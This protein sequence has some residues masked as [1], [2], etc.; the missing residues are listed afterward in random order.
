MWTFST[1]ALQILSHGCCSTERR[2]CFSWLNGRFMAFK[3]CVRNT[4]KQTHSEI[5]YSVTL[6]S[7]HET[8][9]QLLHSPRC[10]KF[11]ILEMQ[12]DHIPT[13]CPDTEARRSQ[14]RQQDPGAKRYLGSGCI[15]TVSIKS[16]LFAY[17]SVPRVSENLTVLGTIQVQNK[18]T[19]IYTLNK[20]SIESWQI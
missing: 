4:L 12:R 17:A 16:V 6:C 15:N 1:P 10:T 13:F 19:Q 8:K 14:G 9:S 7:V 5:L 11:L 3:G 18:L 2:L 20:A